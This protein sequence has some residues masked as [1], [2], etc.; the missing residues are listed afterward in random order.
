MHCLCMNATIR[1]INSAVSFSHLDMSR[2]RGTS[3]PSSELSPRS[4]E[5][6]VERAITA[7]RVIRRASHRRG[8]SYPSSE[9]SQRSH[10]RSVERAIATERVI[11][12]ASRHRAS[13]FGR[14]CPQ[15][16]LVSVR[17]PLF[18][19][20]ARQCSAAFVLG[21]RSFSV[22]PSSVACRHTSPASA[23]QASLGRPSP[24]PVC[25]FPCSNSLRVPWVSP[26][27]TEPT[28]AGGTSAAI[29]SS[30]VYLSLQ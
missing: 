24:V 17:P 6:S 27:V 30:Y 19:A 14:L 25:Q 7:E 16:S 8:T 23:H 1:S 11:R 18:T 26:A 28:T 15:R 29:L 2:R 13:A 5:R 9:A 10:E 3:D 12:R 22:R 20:F 4:H 21:V